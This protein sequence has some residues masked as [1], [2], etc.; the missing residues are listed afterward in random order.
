MRPLEA[1]PSPSPAAT[2]IVLQPEESGALTLDLQKRRGLPA[3]KSIRLVTRSLAC[4][5]REPRRLR[6]AAKT[7]SLRWLDRV[8]V[9]GVVP[10]EENPA[11]VREPSFTRE[12]G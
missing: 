1:A 11:G 5:T 8:L 6:A 3:G 7:S 4:L 12:R 10:A 9:G 2:R